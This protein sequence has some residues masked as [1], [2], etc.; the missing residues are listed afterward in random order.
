MSDPFSRK[1]YLH[2]VSGGA[3][4]L[5]F[6]PGARTR[7]LQLQSFLEGL[8][9][10]LAARTPAERPG[11]PLELVVLS[12][13]DWR[14]LLSAPYGWGLA[15][16]TPAGVVLALPA[17][18]PARL[19]ARWDAVRLRAAQAGV[20]APGGVQAFLDSQL[21]LEWAHAL[22]LSRVQGRA[23]SAWRREV[24]AAYLYGA[25][26]AELGDSARL[27]YLEAWARLGQAGARPSV[28]TPQAFSYP[29]AKGPFDD[30]L[31]T[32]SGLW[33][34]AAALAQRR[35]WALPLGELPAL[36]EEGEE[37]GVA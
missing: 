22:L 7:G 17:A 19:L 32:Q 5:R 26:L 21:G 33:L 27:S 18:Y 20:V 15:R 8:Q 1:T 35:G 37:S 11:G 6:S 16:R 24:A 2:A 30:L 12:A 34:R 10:A 4:P 25:A 28:D 14:Q 29:R 9:N 31:W 13:A 36:L 23:P 3:L